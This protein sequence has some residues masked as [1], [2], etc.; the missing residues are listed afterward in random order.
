MIFK[1][2]VQAEAN[3]P[4]N[5]VSDTLKA[6][7]QG[8]RRDVTKCTGYVISGCRFHT[9]DREQ[10]LVNQN[11]GVSLNATTLQVASAKDKNPVTSLMTYYGVITEIWLLDYWTLKVP[12]FKCDWV[13]NNNGIEVDELGFTSVELG[14]VSHK[15]DPFVL[16]SQAKQ[17]FYVPDQLKPNW[18]IVLASPERD[19]HHD[20]NDEELVDAFNSEP[21]LGKELPDIDIDENPSSYI[22]ADCEGTW[23]KHKKKKKKTKKIIGESSSH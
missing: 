4:D 7:A 23:I 12:L 3:T 15:S 11:S 5:N 2:Q 17:V 13:D 22:R 14:R 10:S 20:D 19:Y 16:A 18:S 8:P 1:I 6:I 21:T 9:K